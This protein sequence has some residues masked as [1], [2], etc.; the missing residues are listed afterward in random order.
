MP[1]HTIN[2]KQVYYDIQ[3]Q[4]TPIL[5]IHGSMSTHR[6][7]YKQRILAKKYALLFLDLPGHGQSEPLEGDIT[8][9]RFAGIVAQLINKMGHKGVFVMGHSLGG[10]ITLQLALDHASLLDGLV[11]V[12][13]GAKLGVLPAILEGLRT[14]YQGGIELATGQ[15]A[16][17]EGADLALVE[18]CK[19]ECLQCPQE[20]GYNDFVACNNFDVRVRLSEI[21]VP[22]LVVVGDEDK[23]TPVKWSQYLADHLRNATLT[24]I[25]QAGHMV[26]LEQPEKLNQAIDA[27]LSK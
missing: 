3:G 1:F 11:L 21:Q 26:M 19:E 27:F 7:W 15:M 10:A 18:R 23:L 17:A 20:V 2:G 6:V 5:M 22:S 24:I 8:V 4:G 12:G 16:F 25:E 13:T 9:Q 14:N